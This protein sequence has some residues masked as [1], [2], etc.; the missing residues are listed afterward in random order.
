MGNAEAL[1][2]LSEI[3]DAFLIHD[4]GIYSRYDDSVARIREG[5]VELIRRARG[6]APFPLDVPFE[7]DLDIL[8][9]GPE[10]KN[11]FCLLSGRHAFVSQHIGDMENV[12]TLEHFEETLALYER[13]FRVKPAMVAYDLH[14][15]YL[16]TK[17]AMELDLPRVGVQHH[18][19]HIVGV[20]AEHGI[21]EPVVGFAF[22][23]TGYG[24][25]GTIWGGEVL[26]SEWGGFERWGHL[27]TVPLVGGSSAIKR[28]ARMAI[29]TL[30]GHDP[31]LLEHPG[32]QPLRARL[33]EG[34]EVLI[35]QMVERGVN[36]PPTSSMGRL[37]DAVA[38][39]AGVRD[40]ARYE[41]QA[42]IE[43]E[44]VADLDSA[45]AYEF[46]LTGTGP[47][48]IDPRPVLAALLEDLAAGEGAPVVS[49]RFHRAVADAIA[50]MAVSA[51]GQVGTRFAAMAG[52]VFMNRLVTTAAE[53]AIESAGLVPLTHI[54]LPTNDGGIS[55]GQAIVAWS[56]RDEI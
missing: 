44:A 30:L 41:G 8:A 6:Y 4:R 7:S 9:V 1:E 25:D 21:E 36:S 34:E 20:A 38:A 39:L 18:H 17:Y 5:R 51:C 49:M 40:D 48:I 52:G 53:R 33:A 37:F 19:A 24:S 32:A 43:L 28:P 50:R 15:E 2:R 46:D 47:L 54:A 23:G 45:G 3:A 55:F 13:M 16:S 56:R 14:P 35:R 22:D 26:V 31:A 29:A 11:T 12:E 27:A 42:A 10:Q